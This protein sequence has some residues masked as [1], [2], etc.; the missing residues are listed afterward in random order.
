ME[1]YSIIKQWHR[2]QLTRPTISAPSCPRR[3]K[4][5]T[6]HNASYISGFATG[7]AMHVVFVG[8]KKESVCNLKK[9]S[10]EVRRGR[11]NLHRAVIRL[12]S[13]THS[14]SIAC[15]QAAA[16][17]I[18]HLWFVPLLT[19]HRTH[20]HIQFHRLSPSSVYGRFRWLVRPSGTLCQQTFA[21]LQTPLF[22]SVISR[23]TF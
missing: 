5:N 20:H 6:T 3:R 7:P 9:N 10:S 2:G 23:H 12:T 4:I 16:W 22:L 17:N 11:M 15:S 21:T 14:G 18:L 8:L 1:R 13:F 19:H